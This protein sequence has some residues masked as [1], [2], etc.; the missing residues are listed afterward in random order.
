MRHV[1]F[2][3]LLA[4]AGLL[5]DE[6]V[7]VFPKLAAPLKLPRDL[8]QTLPLSKKAS[9]F[10][11]AVSVVDC[12]SEIDLP[13]GT[14]GA[15]LFGGL[16]ITSSHLEGAITIRFFPP[17]DDVAHF[18]VTH[19]K[20]AGDDSVLVAPLGYELPVLEN[21]VLDPPDALASGDLDLTTG[22]VSNL[23]Y[24]VLFT[25]T[26]L[27]ALGNVNPKLEAPIIQFP[28]ARGRAWARFQQRADGS[29]DFVFMGETFLPL[30]QDVAGDPVRFP[31]PFCGPG[32][33]CA[34]IPARGSSLHPHLALSNI[35]PSG[36]DCGANCPDIPFNTIQEFTINTRFS[37]FGDDFF[38]DI[39]QLG[40]AG[41]ARSHLQGRLQI[42]FGARSGDTV[43]FVITS[44]VPES[45][46]ATPPESA[47]LGHGPLPGL[48]GQEEFL[49]FPLLTYKLQRVVFV[50]EPYAVPFGHVDLRTGRVIGDMIYPGF[51]GQNIADAV[52][53]QN[54]G[55]IEKQPFH[56][57]AQNSDPNSPNYALFEKGPNGETLF[58]FRGNHVRSFATYRYP[59]PDFTAANSFT[60]GPN[61]Q[62]DLFL[63]LQAAHIVDAP[64]AVKSG[65]ETNV[66]SSLGDRFSYSFSIPCDATG[67]KGA[68]E[69]TN[70]S[71]GSSGG[72]LH[73]VRLASVSCLNSR[74]SRLAAGDYDTVTI[75]GFGTWSKD[76]KD[77]APRL[78][79]FSICLAPEAPYI[80]IL[81]YQN[82]DAS[83]NVILSSANTKPLDKP[84]P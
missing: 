65:G 25:N 82:P 15:Q 74:D 64:R 70:S 39:P 43:P 67:A 73:M 51:F 71:S 13:L 34:S 49:P 17:V 4:A 29:L 84:M 14:C 38:I 2:A 57:V 6:P 69:Y 66:L 50:D 44:L 23:K 58:R 60:G 7:L 3:L 76:K 32:F 63:R 48:L 37:A 19:G 62:L 40:G 12:T 5:A 30:G 54:P 83:N 47:I 35:E 78:V 28:G 26:M 10:G 21:Q 68:F 9:Y 22:G 53:A 80:G 45:L 31:L 11:D 16:A 33:E 41:P 36:L 59:S 52:F 20:L 75:S 27:V 79:T 42:Q 77:A 61:A 8:V 81:V 24:R 1:S 55:R 46:L 18:E 72:T 56:L